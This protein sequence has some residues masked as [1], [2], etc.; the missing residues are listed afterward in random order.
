[1]PLRFG[2]VCYM[3]YQPEEMYGNNFSSSFRLVE[4]N[5]IWRQ[6]LISNWVKLWPLKRLN[7]RAKCKFSRMV[8]TWEPKQRDIHMVFALLLFSFANCIS[9][10][11]I[12]KSSLGSVN[13]ARHSKHKFYLWVFPPLKKHLQLQKNLNRE[14]QKVMRHLSFLLYHPE[15]TQS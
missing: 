14:I 10:R 2:V 12:L 1:M 8:A 5:T 13:R 7:L 15:F 3:E 4:N 6:E 9:L 11:R